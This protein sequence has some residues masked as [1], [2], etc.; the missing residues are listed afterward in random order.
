MIK[1]Y[2]GN[3][4]IKYIIKIITVPISKSCKKENQHI[5]ILEI[6]IQIKTLFYC[7]VMKL[8]F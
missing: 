4:N 7:R 5:K 2:Q 8:N 6:K 1:I 3:H